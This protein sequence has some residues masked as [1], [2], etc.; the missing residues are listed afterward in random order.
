MRRRSGSHSWIEKE[1]IMTNSWI[2][3]K[4]ITPK[5]FR[6]YTHVERM[7]RP[8]V[9][10][11][12]SSCDVSVQPKVD[13]TNASVWG[14]PDGIIHYGS[15]SREIL[16][17]KDNGGF[18]TYMTKMYESDED[19]PYKRLQEWVKAHPTVIVYGEWLGVPESG[20][21]LLGAI[22]SYLE[23]G[24]FVYDVFDRMTGTY[25]LYN[26]YVDELGDVFGKDHIIP[27]I[28]CYRAGSVTLDE[29]VAK[30][31]TFHY[32]LPESVMMEG[33]IIKGQPSFRD[34]Y[35]KIHIGKVVFEEFQKM[36]SIKQTT[37]V[38]GEEER[39]F[40]NEMCTPAFLSK[41]QQKVMTALDDDEWKGDSKHIGMMLQRS[42]DDLMTEEFWNYFRKY[43]GDVNL[44]MI[45]QLVRE[46]ILWFLNIG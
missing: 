43:K 36:K 42:L 28:D 6:A 34:K 25:W 30:C 18:A 35:N 41:T 15:R 8:E 29:I 46:K 38:L 39:S 23:S 20:C 4:N 44:G 40:V 14:T 27:Q 31:R 33:I 32:N 5:T 45:R 13:G 10:D 22:K 11:L 17:T 26:R 16:S 1:N 37:K 24:L 2:D 7:T 21:K 3:E 12:L 19:N 9:A